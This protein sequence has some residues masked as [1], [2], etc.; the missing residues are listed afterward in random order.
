MSANNDQANKEQPIL[1]LIQDIK[2]GRIAPETIDKELR[3]QCIEVF[4]AEGYTTS[5]IAQIFKKTDRTIRRD[6]EDIRAQNA[7]TPDIDLAKKTI[8]EMVVY[9][10]THRAY[11]MR[12]ARLKDASVAEKAQAEYL[13]AR[14]GIELVAR[15]QTLGF[16]PLKPQEIIADISHHVTA[17]NESSFDELRSQIVEIER[18]S[19]ESGELTPE[20]T[21]ELENLKKRIEKA[22]IQDK[23][24]K[25]LSHTDEK[26]KDEK[27]N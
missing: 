10:H 25:I 18:I 27:D 22:E 19:K 3:Q 6:I 23:V 11:L 7:I 2:D 12:L 8:G 15:L 16:L 9:M 17:D 1:A 20:M 21:K 4:L 13:A 24:T 26:G 5:S 14:I